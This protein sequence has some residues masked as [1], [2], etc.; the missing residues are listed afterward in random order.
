MRQYHL[1]LIIPVL[2]ACPACSTDD[3][4]SSSGASTITLRINLP[5]GEFPHDA[6]TGLPKIVAITSVTVTVTAADMEDIVESLTISG[7]TASGT[8]EVP[9]G[10][11]RSFSI[12]CKDGSGI[13]QYSG[14][15][16]QD[17]LND[18]ETVTITT[19]G[20]YPSASTLTITGFNAVSVALSWTTSTDVDFASY[21]LV[22][23]ATGAD[24]TSSLTRESI[25]E[26][27][28]K[29]T[30]TYIDEDVTLDSTYYYAVIVWDTEGLGRRSTAVG[31]QT[32]SWEV[33]G[34]DDGEPAGGYYWETAGQASLNLVTASQPARLIATSFYLTNVSAGGTFRSLAF[35]YDGGGDLT[36]RGEKSVEATATGWFVVS[37]LDSN[38]AVDGNFYVVMMYDGSSYPA[39]GYDLV[40][41]D[42]AFNWNGTTLTAW[43]QTYFMR[44][45][46]EIPGAIL[47]KGLSPGRA[48]I[49]ARKS[50]PFN[51]ELL[52]Q[53]L[54]K[55]DPAMR[56]TM[57]K[58][59]R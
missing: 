25:V 37:Y 17:I 31:V 43:D 58:A 53:L 8:I 1:L 36:T 55:I 9:K 12:E 30:T 14:S 27:T 23:A 42:R 22:R 6:V 34:Y 51:P 24:L 2:F 32:P 5:N 44:A 40:D 13:L 35:V 50:T 21:E 4:L 46:V 16:T 29:S 3:P 18:I 11:A 28:A 54:P 41:N 52:E 59:D 38:I 26:I 7:E 45:L 57:V 19:E 56:G 48:V 33:L 47:T 39:F 10:K 15:T 49:A 20:H